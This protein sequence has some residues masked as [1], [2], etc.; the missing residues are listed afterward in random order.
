LLASQESAFTDFYSAPGTREERIARGGRLMERVNNAVKYVARLYPRS[1]GEACFIDRSGAENARVVHGTIAPP[2]DLSPDETTAPFFRPTFAIPIGSVYQ[3]LPYISPDTRQW[4]ISQATKIDTGRVISPAILHFEVT[5]ESFAHVLASK[6]HDV[7][8]RVV[9]VRNGLVLINSRFPQKIGTE[10]GTPSDVGFGW[11]KTANNG[12]TVSSGGMRHSMRLV[13]QGEGNANQWAVVV[14]T[15]EPTGL[16]AH[17]MSQEALAAG[18]LLG[19][20]CLALSVL[21]YIRHGRDMDLAARRDDLTLLP[22]RLAFRERLNELLREGTPCAVLLLDLNRFKE[23]NDTLGHQAGDD[24]LCEVGQRLQVSLRGHGEAAAR[25]GGDEFVVVA[26]GVTTTEDA[27]RL[28]ER[29]E[30]H[31]EH[32]LG[33]RGVPIRL[34][35]SIG[36]ALLPQ[37]ANEYGAAL[38]CADVAMYAAKERRDGPVVYDLGL[39]MHS[40]QRLGL[41]AQLAQA[42]ANDEL[43]IFYQPIYDVTKSRVTRVEALVR[44]QHPKLGLLGPDEFIPRAEETGFV[45]VITR[46][47]LWKSLDH[48]AEWRLSGLD[49][50]LNVNV[51]AA[52]LS[53]EFFASEV[54]ALLVAQDLPPQCLTLE[55]T[56]S[57]LLVESEKSAVNLRAF[58]AMGV[59]LAVDDFGTGYSSLA[60]LR[61][62]PATQLKIDGSLVSNMVNNPVDALIVRST[63][64]LGRSLGLVV[65]RALRLRS[66][67]P[68][69]FGAEGSYASFATGSPHALA[70]VRADHVV[71]VATR[72]PERLRSAGG[73][74]DQKLELPPGAWVD[75]LTGR[76][77]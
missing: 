26:P 56:E 39:D 63:L 32:T 38:R 67:H 76:D 72:L 24:L 75:H 60:Q 9:D 54:Q 16:R 65:S 43:E 25:L 35:A 55:L 21:G 47:V 19:I 4:V 69:W 49:V 31:L 51:S 53:D 3:S 66:E 45:R 61:M 44:W 18:L 15:K 34:S 30:R 74:A 77:W 33:I 68:A 29:I 62:C 17:L 8:V 1:I 13:A 64:E 41:D 42:V 5:M 27:L 37:H 40:P 22:N 6:S 71:T 58:S 20:C 73:W 11:V 12:T 50:S 46:S 14:S 10:L 48:L 28:A 57:A 70:F 59:G 52:E 2:E 7:E 23:I 36:V